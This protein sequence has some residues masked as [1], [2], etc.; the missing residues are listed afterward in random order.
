M[1]S[2][3]LGLRGVKIRL[4]RLSITF[5]LMTYATGQTLITG[6]FTSFGA[7]ALVVLTAVLGLALGIYV[8]NWGWR[9]IKKGGKG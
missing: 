3:F 1:C 7:A 6:S 4:S 8:V 2:L 9:K 5:V